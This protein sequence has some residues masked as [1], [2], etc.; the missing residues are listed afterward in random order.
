MAK[1]KAIPT[2]PSGEFVTDKVASRILGAAHGRDRTRTLMSQGV[3]RAYRIGG[4]LVTTRRDVEEYVL[5]IRTTHTP[6]QF[7][8]LI[9]EPTRR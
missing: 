8:S 2:A 4:T 6:A 5:A 9:I 3:I 1:R 7:G